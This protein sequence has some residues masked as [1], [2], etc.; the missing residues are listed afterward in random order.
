MHFAAL[1]AAALIGATWQGALLAL[2]VWLCLRLMPAVSAAVRSTVW[3]SSFAIVFV[4]HFVPAPAGS[5]MAGHEVH[6]APVWS[7][8]LVAV[9]A[10]L[11]LFRA[12]QLGLSVERV[13]TVV[14]RA[15][16]VVGVPGLVSGALGSS[17]GSKPGSLPGSKGRG[18]TVCVSPD[19]DRPSVLGFWNPRVLLP[20]GLIESLTP[21]ELQ[22]VLLHETEHLRR[23]DDWTNLLQ[24][25]ALVVFPLNPVLIWI[26]RRL[27]LER[28]L[29]CDDRVLAETGARK[30][31]ALCLTQL[32]EHSMLQRGLTL[33]LGA[34]GRQSELAAR[35][36]RILRRPE[37]VLSPVK[38]RLAMAT[39]LVGV[40]GASV[41]LAR[42]PRLVSFMPVEVAPAVQEAAVR[43][44]GLTGG[45]R[46]TL[47]KA[48]MPGPVPVKRVHRADFGRKA[49]KP[50]GPQWRTTWRTTGI[51]RAS[52]GRV[53][54]VLTS[55]VVEDQSGERVYVP[56]VRYVPATYAAVQTPEGWVI[57]RL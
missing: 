22:Q 4:L 53:R 13:R 38:M 23:S 1:A 44:P 40:V 7:V 46:M 3:L 17:T 14:R 35:V 18:Y 55:A 15:V 45:A 57:F 8:A 30:A 33:A 12:I 21:A 37:R 25:V 36:H 19:V 49:D 42:S 5:A 26:E 20:E 16:P 31:Y 50:A 28:E 39:M 2:L 9:W 24:K 32:A 54:V 56:V 11:S 47:A 41:A 29:A 34:W 48:V 6:A 51:A 52:E 27:C 10:G 43:V